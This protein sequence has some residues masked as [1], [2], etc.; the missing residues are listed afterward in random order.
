[1]RY[2]LKKGEDKKGW[3][4]ERKVKEGLKTRK[5]RF[6]QKRKAESIIVHGSMYK[7]RHTFFLDQPE[8]VALAM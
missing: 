1:M 2:L 4:K 6:S 8:D 5:E 7:K 3:W